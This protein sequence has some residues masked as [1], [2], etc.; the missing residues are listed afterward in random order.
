M[1]IINWHL[2]PHPFSL[3]KFLIC[4]GLT[5]IRMRL[6]RNLSTGGKLLLPA[7]ES[8][9]NPSILNAGG[10]HKFKL[11][12]FQWTSFE[13]A[14]CCWSHLSSQGAK[15]LTDSQALPIA[16]QQ[17]DIVNHPG[18][19]S[20]RAYLSQIISAHSRL[21]SQMIYTPRDN[22]TLAH[23]LARAA[24]NRCNITPLNSCTNSLHRTV[25]CPLRQLCNSQNSATSCYVPWEETFRRAKR[26]KG[27]SPGT[28]PDVIN[29][30]DE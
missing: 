22:N 20:I 3:P 29:I 2:L 5:S 16:C 23:Q 19:W 30:V 18:H 25:G 17:K 27:I 6:E 13:M 10:L 9:L 26:R 11:P 12:P 1:S 4:M 7:L 21:N 28:G 24:K 8:S 15:Q 14:S